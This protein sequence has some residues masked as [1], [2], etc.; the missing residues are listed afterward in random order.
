MPDKKLHKM[1]KIGMAFCLLFFCLFS[2]FGCAD[3][4]DNGGAGFTFTDAAG[5]TVCVEATERV[6]C[7]YG[8]YA[9]VWMLA[10]GNVL[11]ATEDVVSG[12]D[13]GLPEETLVIGTVKEPNLEAILALEPDFVLLSADIAAHVKAAETFERAGI[14][15]AFVHIEHFEDYLETLHIFT[16]IT[17]R[18]DLYEQNGLAV[19]R[20]VAQILERDRGEQVPAV[21]FLRAYSSGADAKGE[22]SMVGRMLQ[23]LGAENI[24]DRHPS[25]LE[26]LSVEEII[27]AD[28]DYIFVSIMGSD[29]EAAIE[30][31]NERLWSNKAFDEL[32]ALREE[33]RYIVLDKSLFHYKPNAR[34][35]QAYE[36]LYETLYDEE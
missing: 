35:A 1:G 20:E 4:A 15:C 18:E 28:P 17:G 7:A 32:R 10:G 29:S 5:R 9:E 25:L 22:D 33:G 31:L 13:V 14:A 23:D 30:A 27:L 21:L 11:A 16:Q 36:F 34:W 24:V 3:Q 26:N 8:S 6:V 19:G 2:F 12:R